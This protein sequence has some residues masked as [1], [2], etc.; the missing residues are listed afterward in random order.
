MQREI[1]KVVWRLN[2]VVA[3]VDVKQPAKRSDG[4]HC[5]AHCYRPKPH[6]TEAHERRPGTCVWGG[7]RLRTIPRLSFQLGT[8]CSILVRR[9]VRSPKISRNRKCRAAHQG[10]GRTQHS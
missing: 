3:A 10:E 4:E 8:V 6:S 7:F 5:K 1:A 9:R 2:F